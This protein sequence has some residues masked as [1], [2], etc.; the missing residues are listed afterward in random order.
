MKYE[1]PVLKVFLA[2]E[3][4]GAEC[5]NGST[6]NPVCSY[7][8]NVDETCYGGSEANSCGDGTD[9]YGFCPMGHGYGGIACAYGEGAVGQ[10]SDGPY[11]T[12]DCMY[13]YSGA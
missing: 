8:G 9:A 3:A 13:G 7:G 2:D 1:K 10:C 5:R 6:A 12:S 11:A 4:L